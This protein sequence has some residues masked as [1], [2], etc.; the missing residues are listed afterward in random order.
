[1]T[2]RR[3]T[4]VIA[5][6]HEDQ[7]ALFAMACRRGGFD[8]LEAAD[9]Q[10]LVDVVRAQRAAGTLGDVGLVISDIMMPGVTGFDALETLRAEGIVVPFLFVSALNDAA[11]RERALGLRALGIFVKPFELATLLRFLHERLETHDR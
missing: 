2:S 11:T 4:I 6:D 1:M 5:E 8:V 7:R 9:G 3:Q 10:E